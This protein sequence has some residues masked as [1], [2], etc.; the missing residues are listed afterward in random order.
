MAVDA[1]WQQPVSGPER[2]NRVIYRDFRKSH[3]LSPAKPAPIQAFS[4]SQA[5][6]RELEQ[7]KN[8]DSAED[9]SFRALPRLAAA[10]DQSLRATG[11]RDSVCAPHDIDDSSAG[12]R[13]RLSATGATPELL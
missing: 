10:K 3:A 11:L 6:L 2:W 5:M 1:V 13:S 12:Y 4:S 8:R 9:Q 7:G